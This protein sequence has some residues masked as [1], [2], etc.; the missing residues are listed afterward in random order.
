MSSYLERM[1]DDGTDRDRWLATREGRIGGS[2]AA[3]FAKLDS[4]PLYARD[5]R[6]TFSGNAFTN[7]GNAREDFLLRTFNI[8]RNVA[9]FHAEGNERHV[10]TPDGIRDLTSGL[11]LAEAKTTNKP[12]RTIPR[13]YLRQIW[14]TQY[15]LG[16]E[17]TLIVWEQHDGF[18]PIDFEPKSSF[19]ERDDTEIAQLIRIADRVLED[20]DAAADYEKE[21]INA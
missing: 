10:A 3:K 4:A 19:I 15:V 21:L 12:W 7:H 5:K 8:P 18:V 17:R 11:L 9:L 1:L 16:A 2:D 13:G 20:L 6:R 14:W